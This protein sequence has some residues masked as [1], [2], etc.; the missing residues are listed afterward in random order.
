MP[1]APMSGPD[2]AFGIPLPFPLVIG[3]L[4]R[5]SDGLTALPH[6]SIVRLHATARQ[7]TIV[8]K[9]RLLP[10]SKDV[11]GLPQPLRKK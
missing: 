7:G 8:A 1:G 4:R 3:V 2:I 11:A 10:F 5:T 9:S 6:G